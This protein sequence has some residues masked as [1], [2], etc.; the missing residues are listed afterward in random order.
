[1]VHRGLAA[2][3]AIA[4]LAFASPAAAQLSSSASGFSDAPAEAH[5]SQYWS[6]LGGLGS[7]LAKQ[8]PE[9]ARAFVATTIDSAEET[10]A[11]KALFH[12]RYNVC[13]SNFIR[14]DM[15]RAH[16]RGVIA[17]GLFEGIDGA[18]VSDRLAHLPPAPD[19]IST[20]HDFARCYVVAHPGKA[21][22]L[23]EQ[24]RLATKGEEAFVREIAGD[25]APCLP[26]G[27]TA[28]LRPTVARFAIAEALYRVATG[29]PVATI[30]SGKR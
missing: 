14:A 11:F 1:M 4:S 19:A 5:E 12:R 26:Q 6:M 21:R 29:A 16:V 27:K 30:A 10:K 3:S 25:F 23:L 24:T 2:M 13:M 7:C 18:A 9:L 28:S 22:D 20:L 15:V 17:E 8:K